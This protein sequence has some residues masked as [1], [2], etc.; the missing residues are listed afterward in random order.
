[1]HLEE[2]LCCLCCQSNAQMQGSDRIL[3]VVCYIPSEVK[4]AWPV[5]SLAS[6]S[7]MGLVCEGGEYRPLPG[8]RPG[9]RGLFRVNLNMALPCTGSSL[10]LLTELPFAKKG[11]G[12]YSQN[13]YLVIKGGLLD[14]TF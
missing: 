4:L 1:M 3:C 9:L 5:C 13:G 2:L 6:L 12:L 11:K 8:L 10:R 14:F 7:A